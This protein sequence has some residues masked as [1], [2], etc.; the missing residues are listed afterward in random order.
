M[1]QCSPYA[2]HLYSKSKNFPF[3]C[4][5]NLVQ[6]SPPTNSTADFC[7]ETWNACKDVTI[8]NSPFNS[9]SP[10]KLSD[11]YKGAA[12]FCSAAGGNASDQTVCFSGGMS[13]GFNATQPA[14][15]PQGTFSLSLSLSLST[16][17]SSKDL[18][19][20]YAK[21]EI[22]CIHLQNLNIL[23]LLL[24]FFS[25]HTCCLMVMKAVFCIASLNYRRT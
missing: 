4:N 10:N 18:K 12:D 19:C 20:A 22:C 13:V 17:L 15:P 9:A 5:S 23:Y 24:S 1:Q 11:S 2:F 3:L 16:F 14:P 6:S 25:K 21:K 7:T 8:T